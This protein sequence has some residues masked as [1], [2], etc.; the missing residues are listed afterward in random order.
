MLLPIVNRSF[1]C[2]A[3]GAFGPLVF[4]REHWATVHHFAVPFGNEINR[5]FP[6]SMFSIAQQEHPPRL[7]SGPELDEEKLYGSET[8][9]E[10]VICI[11]APMQQNRVSFGR[12][13][14]IVIRGI[15]AFRFG[16]TV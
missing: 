1:S 2:I 12:C 7:Q 4:S 11:P 5:T 10:S 9:G 13:V 8:R 16:V 14:E 3:Q 6:I 15:T